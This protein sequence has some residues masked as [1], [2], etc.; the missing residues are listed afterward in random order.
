[1]VVY[2]YIVDFASVVGIYRCACNTAEAGEELF[3]KR[4]KRVAGR[5]FH[6]QALTC[7]GL[8]AEEVFQSSEIGGLHVLSENPLPCG[9][10]VWNGKSFLEGILPNPLLVPTEIPGQYS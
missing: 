6:N 10:F 1:V 8:K 9:S 2:A 4:I 3:R 7:G 5:F